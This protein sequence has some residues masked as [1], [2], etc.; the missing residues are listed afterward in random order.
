MNVTID[1]HTRRGIFKAEVG[2]V[3]EIR[4]KRTKVIIHGYMGSKSVQWVE[5]M[6][7]ELLRDV[8]YILFVRCINLVYLPFTILKQIVS[9]H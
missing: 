5:D 7:R 9:S 1:H 6:A 4:T 8:R 2:Y 3:S